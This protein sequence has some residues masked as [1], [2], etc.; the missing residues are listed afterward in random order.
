MSI[1]SVNFFPVQS[2]NWTVDEFQTHYCLAQEDHTFIRW[3]QTLMEHTAN[4]LQCLKDTWPPMTQS[5]MD[6]TLDLQ[7]L[8]VTIVHELHVAMIQ[9]PIQPEQFGHLLHDGMT[10]KI[11]SSHHVLT[12]LVSG[13]PLEHSTSG[14]ISPTLTLEDNEPRELHQMTMWKTI[15]I[16]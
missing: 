13:P 6:V 4:A 15:T 8:L 9:G 14:Q 1:Q 3:L 12:S 11:P 2:L 7:N 5:V 16:V 10:L